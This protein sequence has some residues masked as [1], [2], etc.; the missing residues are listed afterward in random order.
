[1]REVG[2]GKSA[3]AGAGVDVDVELDV[4]INTACP[5]RK[6]GSEPFCEGATVAW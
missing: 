3:V 4:E 5:G 2:V 1:M 6:W